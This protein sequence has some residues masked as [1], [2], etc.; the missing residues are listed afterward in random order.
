M[1]DKKMP[2]FEHHFM[3]HA[4]G[5]YKG[6]KYL[7]NEDALKYSLSQGHKFFEVD[8]FLTADHR[9]V[10][11]HGWDEKH[12]K[13]CGMEYSP[14]FEHMTEEMF[15]RQ[16]LFGMDT[17]SIATLYKY[18]KDYPDIYLELDLHAENDED[19]SEVTK[20]LLEAFHNDE[21]VLDR[22]LVQAHP[23]RF[24]AIDSVYHFK[25]YQTFLHKHPPEELFRDVLDYA[26]DH[27]IGSIALSV[28][29]ADE[30]N[31]KRMND[32]GLNVL[33][34][35]LDKYPK[36]EQL[37]SLGADTICTNTMSPKGERKYKIKSL[38]PVKLLR[39]IYGRLKKVI[40]GK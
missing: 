17:M 38:P 2:M 13:T 11:S 26:V 7:N 23:S 24:E 6:H 19:T 36:A 5:G 28:H 35:T 34:Y 31:I 8:L 1:P 32:K 12:A 9:V 16:K 20:L 30:N 21:Q 39:K 25:Y 3:A 18:M 15:L 22:L 37:L 4:L 33:I 14:E 40:S 29:D 27:G 10:P